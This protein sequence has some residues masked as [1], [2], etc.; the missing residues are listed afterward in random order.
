MSRSKHN[1]ARNKKL[2]LNFSNGTC[3]VTSNTYIIEIQSCVGTDIHPP[4]M[5][6]SLVLFG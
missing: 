2:K 1:H 3:K 4:I 6:V 5:F